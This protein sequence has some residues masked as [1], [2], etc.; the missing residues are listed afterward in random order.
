MAYVVCVPERNEIVDD[1]E[2]MKVCVWGG[3][4][5]GERQWA[6]RQ[7]DKYADGWMDE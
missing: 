3:G 2:E 1:L 7:T 4:G 5:G 6:Y